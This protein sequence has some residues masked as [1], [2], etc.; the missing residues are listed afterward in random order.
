MV[1][2]LS[3]CMTLLIGTITELTGR[4]YE[5]LVDA[6]TRSTILARFYDG[7]FIQIQSQSS[8]SADSSKASNEA[9]LV[10]Q[11]TAQAQL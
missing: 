5:I 8:N 10:L 2:A 11:P 7:R 1:P 4:G 6:Q 9:T 3:P